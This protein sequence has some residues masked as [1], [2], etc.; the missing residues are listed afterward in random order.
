MSLPKA[1]QKGQI[2]RVKNPKTGR[3]TCLKATG[4]VGFGKYKIVS[5][6]EAKNADKNPHVQ[7]AEV[8]VA[9]HG[10]K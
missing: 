9:G 7:N 3:E 8:W 5:C 10:W 1:P 2:Y 6:K 4:K